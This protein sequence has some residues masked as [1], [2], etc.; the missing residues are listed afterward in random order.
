MTL[1][2][3]IAKYRKAMALSQEDLANILNVSRQAVYKWESDQSTPELEKLLAMTSVFEVS[4]DELVTGEKPIGNE[5]TVNAD[6]KHTRHFIAGLVFLVSGIVVTFTM[7]LLSAS[8]LGAVIGLPFIVCAMICFF[9]HKHTALW[10][11]WTAFIFAD[12]YM[13][14]ATGINPSHI[15]QSFQWTYEMNYARLAFAWIQFI[16]ILLMI[17]VSVKSFGIP[18]V[19]KGRQAV[20]RIVIAAVVFSVLYVL[21]GFDLLW[22]FIGGAHPY[23]II[24]PP[25]EEVYSL[26]MIS[27][28]IYAVRMIA[29]MRKSKLGG[30]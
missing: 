30:N 4:L 21:S 27:V 26:L 19:E 28:A 7:I 18:K 6:T 2:E 13:R 29:G 16:V 1:G 23:S 20:T 15:L 17:A 25:R 12:L 5:V 11:G 14:Y 9:V 8:I 10:C 22:R 24:F 3:H